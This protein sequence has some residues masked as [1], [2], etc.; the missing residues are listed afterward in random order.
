M[1]YLNL[2]SGHATQPSVYYLYNAVIHVFNNILLTQYWN[3]CFNNILLFDMIISNFDISSQVTALDDDVNFNVVYYAID[4]TDSD[5]TY[6]DIDPYTGV[7]SVLTSP[8]YESDPQILT[9]GIIAT[10]NGGLTT[11]STVT[12]TVTDQNDNAPYF[13]STYYNY[14]V[15]S[16]AYNGYAVGPVYATDIET[17]KVHAKEIF[18]LWTN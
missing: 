6:F 15:R 18:K 1:C 16:D 5:G 17:G 7:L 14:E 9:F 12:M 3:T 10:D 2:I 11:T 4:P 8:D 13:L